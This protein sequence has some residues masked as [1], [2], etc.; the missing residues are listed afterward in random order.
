MTGTPP[1]SGSTGKSSST[2]GTASSRR[3]R[4]RASSR[5]GG[6]RWAPS[7]NRY[8]NVAGW[9]LYSPGVVNIDRSVVTTFPITARLNSTST[10]RRSI[11]S[12]RPGSASRTRRSARPPSAAS[13]PPW[14]RTAA[15]CCRA[16]S[17]FRSKTGRPENGAPKDAPVLLRNAA[18]SASAVAL[19]TLESELAPRPNFRMARSLTKGAFQKQ[20][21]G[22][23][24]RLY[25]SQAIESLRQRIRRHNPI[26]SRPSPISAIVPGSG[27]S[28]GIPTV[29]GRATK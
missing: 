7:P 24:A 15:C 14:A 17:C 23:P 8:G 16:G 26:P 10:L 11:F 12:S 5:S 29:S 28:G 20:K 27:I 2:R 4:C 13:L 18:P 19:Q 25:G 6:A 9:V 21:G 3:R 1:R 22:R